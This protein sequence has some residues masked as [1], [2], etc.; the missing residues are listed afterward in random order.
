MSWIEKLYRTYENNAGHIGDRNDEVPLLPLCHTTQNA[1]VHI[2][3]N[4]SGN[5]I[6]A[7]VIPKDQ[8]RTVI[9]AREDSA[10]R[11]SGPVPH[12]LCDKL[13]YVAADYEKYGGEKVHCFDQ[14][15]SQLEKWCLSPYSHPKV[16]GVYDYVRKG[17]SI[18][19]LVVSKVL[20]TGADGQLLKT[21][22]GSNKDA[23]EIFNV[24]QGKGRQSDA[25]VRFSVEIPGDP[26]C[27]LWTDATVWKSWTD[28]YTTTRSARGLCYVTG[29]EEFLADQHP[30]KIRNSGD[31]AKLISSND[32]SGYTFRG[33]F[34]IADEAC[35]VGFEVTQKAH[36]ALRWLIARQGRRDGEQAI[37]AWAVSGAEIPD[38][39]ADTFSFLFEAETESPPKITGYTAQD[40]GIRLSQMIAGYSVNLG[41]TEDVVVLGLDS[42][43]PGR[44]A[45]RFYREL[46]G[47]EFL[48]RVQTWHKGCCWLQKFG[49]EKV[50]VGAPSPR[51]IAEAA[52]GKRIDDNLRKATVER[53]LP[54]IVDGAPIPR[55][56]V[57]SCARRASN[58]SAYKGQF[59]AGLDWGSNWDWEKI[60]GIA[61]AL[62][63]HHYKERGYTM[64]LDRDRKT[65]DYLF[66]RLLAAA[67]GLE[68]WALK[69]AD[70]KRQ[71]NASRM[72]Q[73]F[74]D[75]PCSTWR[76]IELAL[77]PYKARL[78]GRA[79]KYLDVIDEIMNAFNVPDY[80][81]DSPLSG[82]FLLGFHSQ[83][84]AFWQ[85]PE[86][87]VETP[88]NDM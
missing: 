9:P 39:L 24:I 17:R 57:E 31:K 88:E 87:D 69:L 83:R 37:V 54:C 62:Y 30:A 85:N 45:I 75:R 27:N 3:L 12:P 32:T 44:M 49:T 59:N 77:S 66:G 4:G 81:C 16:G 43:T 15:L 18:E 70:E 60:L 5:F 41:S 36:N 86:P 52:Y 53:L 21:W 76:T 79:K 63:K 1:Q 2:V 67:D 58:R 29:K 34:T 35:G 26:Q 48:E 68:S 72:M 64:A 11:T 22:E 51:D 84:A 8:G 82:E 80:V 71:T 74:A 13:Q 20:H 78:G 38:P 7:N 55:D 28:Y 19:D 14:Y 56:L 73:R 65:R 23:P 42:A 46:T 25:F 47:S 33:R 61:C 50:F 10:G 6:R 40:T